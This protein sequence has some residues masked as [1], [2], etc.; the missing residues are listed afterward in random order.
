MNFILQWVYRHW[1]SVGMGLL[2][3]WLS[4]GVT[5]VTFLKPTIKVSGN[6]KYIQASDGLQP[7]FG[8]AMSQQYIGWAHRKNR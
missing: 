8:C 2:L 7:T 1:S 3:C 4:I 6:A 5:Y